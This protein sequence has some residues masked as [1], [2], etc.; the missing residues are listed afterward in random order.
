ML[1]N[2]NIDQQALRSWI[3]A[4]LAIP[5]VRQLKGDAGY[6]F[7]NMIAKYTLSAN[8]YRLSTAALGRLRDDGVDLEA[9]YSRRRFYGKES[10]FIYEHAIPA[11]VI[12]QAL[13]ESDGLPDT[14]DKILTQAGFVAMILREEDARLKAMGLN[15]RMPS[16]WSLGQSPLVRYDAAGIT[17]SP[18]LLK[19][20]GGIQR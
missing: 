16:D 5:A 9:T 17:I 11:V 3:T 2:E 14:V 20:K 1:D 4:G 19:I 12:R 6:L 7:N 18:A 15:H 8:T 13:L 10:V